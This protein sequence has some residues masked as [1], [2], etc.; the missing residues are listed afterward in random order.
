MRA[1]D[2]ITATFPTK[3][4]FIPRSF[5]AGPAHILVVDDSPTQRRQM[6]MIL[7]QDGF[8]VHCAENGEAAIEAI[9]SDPPRLVVTDLEMPG[10]SG[11]ELVAVVSGM[12]PAVPV[13][14]T[15]S[16]G[17]ESI[18]AEALRRGASSYVPKHDMASML[19]PVVRQVLSIHHAAQSVREVA[20]YAVEATL[21]LEL[22]NDETLVPNVIARLELPLVELGLFDEGERMQI[23]MALDEALVNAI[24]H[25][26]LAVSSE[27]RQT[28]DGKDYVDAIAKRKTTSPY[29]D[30]RVHVS[31]H[32]D[33]E[34]ATFTIRD[35]GGGFSC[36]DL[37]DP[38]K[39]ENLE[40][41]GGRGLLL[42]HAFMDEVRHNDV[43]N[44]IVMIK[45]KGGSE[46]NDGSEDS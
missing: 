30:R 42:I 14:L 21:R 37:R 41:A 36:A 27:L 2:S 3:Q 16:E 32:A 20:K 25:G 24:I 8:V 39:P 7:E 44:E 17:S 22:E 23:A 13:V 18:A 28:E 19:A 38:T 46:D 31:L 33:K 43:G 40:R 11:L 10:I 5:M 35:E 45:R 9:H 4:R 34:Q 6:Q 29:R 1:G 15:T 26:N 12:Q